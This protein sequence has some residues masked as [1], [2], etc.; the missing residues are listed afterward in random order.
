MTGQASSKNETGSN[1]ASPPAAL[2]PW[3]WRTTGMALLCAATVFA[4]Y[5]A[6]GREIWSGDSVPA[7]YLTCALFAE[8]DFTLTVI[9]LWS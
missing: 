7:K 2:A 1:A 3:T 8:T 4:I 6:N 5:L 9:V